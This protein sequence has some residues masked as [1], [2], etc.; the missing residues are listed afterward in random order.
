[1]PIVAA[2]SHPCECSFRPSLQSEQNRK[3]TSVSLVCFK[4]LVAC[5]LARCDAPG[6]IKFYSNKLRLRSYADD[7]LTLCCTSGL[8]R[9]FANGRLR[10]VVN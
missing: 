10:N 9:G 1:M 8:S 6:V 4:Q 7:L 5:T 2:E 3:R